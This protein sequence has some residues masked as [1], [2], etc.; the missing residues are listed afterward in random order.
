MAAAAVVG[1]LVGVGTLFAQAGTPIRSLEISLWPE[2][3]DPRILVILTGSLEQEEG[4]LV[5]PLPEGADVN[6]VAS[7][8]EG[9]PLT[10]ADWEVDG[11]DSSL[12]LIVRLTAARFQVEYYLDAVRPGDETFLSVAIPM[13]D[14]SVAEARLEVQQPAQ[15]TALSGDPA[16]GEPQLGFA[17]LN[18]FSRDLGSLSGG[19]LVR[20]E[21]R[22]VRLAP[23]LSVPPPATPPSP[24]PAES[25]QP[26]LRLVAAGGAAAAGLVL[27]AF[28]FLTRRGLPVALGRTPSAQDGSAQFCHN[29]GRRFEPGDRYCAQCG[30]ARRS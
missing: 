11:S 13:P 8:E 16:L 6:A 5:L 14:A 19:E 25:R 15:A 2:Y 30:M 12:T 28:W 23:G 20:Q 4:T 9:G 29:C 26:D 17:G 10:D 7:A 24:A 18:Y 21:V 22:Y 3:D 1:W 27:I